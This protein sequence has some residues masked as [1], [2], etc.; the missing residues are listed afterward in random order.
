M[1]YVAVVG[2]MRRSDLSRGVDE[3]TNYMTN[4][5]RCKL[6]FRQA[7]DIK[8]ANIKLAI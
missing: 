2:V 4:G 5:G 8:Y 7:R 1:T 6:A 3:A